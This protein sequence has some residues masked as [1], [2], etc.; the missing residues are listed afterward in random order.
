MEPARHCA[1]EKF[2]TQ[3]ELNKFYAGELEHGESNSITMPT[4]ILGSC[5]FINMF[6]R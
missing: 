5:V 4:N 6:G 3:S 2:I 1:R